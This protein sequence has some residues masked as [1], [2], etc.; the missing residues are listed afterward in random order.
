MSQRAFR[1]IFFGMLALYVLMFAARAVYDLITFEEA[2]ISA[3]YNIYYSG[4]KGE[5]I[6]NYASLS[7][8]FAA[9]N[10][11][12]ATLDQKYE[13]I[14]SITSKTVRYN[15]DIE[16]LKAA[17][18]KYKAVVQME[19]SRGL[20]DSRQ[21]D[22]V[23]GVR[24]ESFDDMQAEVS[25]IG[26]ITSTT[27]TKT[28]MTYEYRQMLAEKE[29]LERRMASYEELKERG[30]SVAEMLQL[31]EKIIEVEAM[32]Q[33]QLIGLGEYSDDNALC[34]INFSLYEGN[35]AGVM[36]K[37]WNALTWT[38]GTYLAIVGIL[39]LTL[40]AAYVLVK[41]WALL[42]RTVVDRPAQAGQASPNSP[43]P[44]VQPQSPQEPRPEG[45]AEL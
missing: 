12:T 15:E 37:L 9:G 14:A 34:T 13:R 22:M 2:D 43:P 5:S 4:D 24:P 40:F 45:P 1:R 44:P 8:E 21:V 39:L 28:D 29:T 16:K 42:K 17:I 31:Q 20:V 25:Q 23:I 18:E 3:N 30:G 10:A 26:R 11:G 36:R 27:V 6:R 32:I 7:M 33:Q 38:T 41:F 35:E 19:N